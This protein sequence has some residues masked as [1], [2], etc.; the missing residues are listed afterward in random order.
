MSRTAKMD[1]ISL[2]RIPRSGVRAGDIVP[3][4]GKGQRRDQDRNNCDRHRPPL[5]LV[6]IAGRRQKSPSSRAMMRCLHATFIERAAIKMA[7]A[8]V[9]AP[10]AL[11]RVRLVFMNW[12]LRFVTRERPSCHIRIGYW[13]LSMGELRTTLPVYTVERNGRFHC[14]RHALKSRRYRIRPE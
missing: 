10:A 3:R 4:D 12:T 11:D 13:C 14:V 5:S 7:L 1:W 8:R 2:K 6:E 9:N